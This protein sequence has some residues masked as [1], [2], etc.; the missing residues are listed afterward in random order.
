[1]RKVSGGFSA[2]AGLFSTK[3]KLGRCSGLLVLLG[4]VYMETSS[5]SGDG[6]TQTRRLRE[7]SAEKGTL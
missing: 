5:I 6:P 1:M 2:G 7:C 3:R 4:R